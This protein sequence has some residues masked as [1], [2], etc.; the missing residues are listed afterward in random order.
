MKLK[1]LTGLYNLRGTWKL[2]SYQI[3]IEKEEEEEN[4]L[5]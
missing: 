3:F 4:E 2:Y 5:V 1:K